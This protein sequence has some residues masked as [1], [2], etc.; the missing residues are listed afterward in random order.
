MWFWQTWPKR[1]PEGEVYTF[2]VGGIT[3]YLCGK[4]HSLLDSKGYHGCVMRYGDFMWLKGF[5]RK[6]G[7]LTIQPYLKVAGHELQHLLNHA[8]SIVVNP[9]EE[10]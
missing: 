3:V 10:L 2:K 4:N 5:R 9:D 7:L 8:D 1:L 6:D